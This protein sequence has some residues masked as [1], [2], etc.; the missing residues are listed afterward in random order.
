M[1]VYMCVMFLGTK[2]G[3]L[4]LFLISIT[5]IIHFVSLLHYSP[6]CVQDTY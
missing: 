4:F 5:S 1:E 3:F 6:G 2:E